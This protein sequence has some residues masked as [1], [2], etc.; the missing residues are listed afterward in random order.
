MYLLHIYIHPLPIAPQP[1]P[2]TPHAAL[3]APSIRTTCSLPLTASL[4]FCTKGTRVCTDS[5]QKFAMCV[6]ANNSMTVFAALAVM[7]MFG[8]EP[9]DVERSTTGVRKDMSSLSRLDLVSCALL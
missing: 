9:C 3:S 4:N 8:F 5:F 6:R 7:R 1:S 2:A